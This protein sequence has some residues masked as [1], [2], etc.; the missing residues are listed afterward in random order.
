MTELSW[1]MY[2]SFTVW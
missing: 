2:N 1:P